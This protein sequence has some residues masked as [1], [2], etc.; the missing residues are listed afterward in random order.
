[1]SVGLPSEAVER[2]WRFLRVAR[3]SFAMLLPCWRNSTTRTVRIAPGLFFVLRNT[4]SATFV[5]GNG[6][7]LDFFDVSIGETR[8]I[9][10]CMRAACDAHEV[11]ELET[12]PLSWRI[13]SRIGAW[14]SDGLI[15]ARDSETIMI[16]IRW[17][18]SS[19]AVTLHRREII[20]IVNEFTIWLDRL[21]SKLEVS[22][23]YFS[24]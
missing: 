10:E 22:P 13:D 8:R 12:G 6:D 17:G 14:R 4:E 1:M 23:E 21:C 18:S 24:C 2:F 20:R 11:H 19:H 5:R 15:S 16:T 3:S 9:F 7:D